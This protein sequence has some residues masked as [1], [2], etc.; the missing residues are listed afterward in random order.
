MAR[1]NAAMDIQA[2][3]RVQLPYPPALQREVDHFYGELLGLKRMPPPA[4]SALRFAARGQRIDLVAT[5]HAPA[6]PPGL[7][8][9]SFEV[10]GLPWLRRRLLQAQVQIEEHV[11]LAGYVRFFVHDP[12]GNRLEFLEPDVY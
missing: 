1:D 9:L 5:P 7:T 3:S 8:P 6:A 10:A 11:P 4:D 12:A 2:I